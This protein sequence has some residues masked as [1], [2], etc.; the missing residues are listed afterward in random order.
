MSYVRGKVGGE[1]RSSFACLLSIV[2][3]L[4]AGVTV[5]PNVIY[6]VYVEHS[7]FVCMPY[8]SIGV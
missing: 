2:D 5:L 7:N 4:S 1:H 6:L 3:P 8:A